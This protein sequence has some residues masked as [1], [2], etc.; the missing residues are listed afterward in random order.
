LHVSQPFT[1][2]HCIS[3]RPQ[4]CLLCIYPTVYTFSW[5]KNQ[6][7]FKPRLNF[8]LNISAHSS[9]SSVP[10]SE[11]QMPCPKWSAAEFVDFCMNINHKHCY[12]LYVNLRMCHNYDIREISGASSTISSNGD[13]LRTTS[14]SNQCRI[15]TSQF[16]ESFEGNMKSHSQYDAILY[17]RCTTGPTLFLKSVN[18]LLLRHYTVEETRVESCSLSTHR[19]VLPAIIATFR[20]STASIESWQIKIYYCTKNSNQSK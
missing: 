10:L 5:G 16:H 4:H 2:F 12:P 11:P 20:I 15:Q 19:P 7:D 8:K 14:S 18:L 9:Q 13:V 1:L 17:E 6:L 3:W